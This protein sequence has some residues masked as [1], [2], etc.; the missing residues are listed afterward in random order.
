MRNPENPNDFIADRIVSTPN[1][2]HGKPRIAGTRIMVYLILDRLARGKTIEEI[3]EKDYP[4]ITREDILA[5]IA[6]ASKV[7]QKESVSK[8]HDPA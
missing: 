6:Y 5:C 4:T 3:I 1:I 7:L 2:V 8:E